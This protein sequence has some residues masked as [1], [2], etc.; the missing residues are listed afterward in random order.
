MTDTYGPLAIPVPVPAAGTAG[1]DPLLDTLLA[2]FKAALD[3]GMAEA[4]QARAPDGDAAV[5]TVVVG[6]PDL[7]GIPPQTLPALYLHRSAMGRPVWDASDWRVRP[8]TLLLSY[9]WPLD[10]DQD[11]GL[12]RAAF[13]NAAEAILDAAIERGRTPGWVHPGDL[14]MSEVDADGTSP[15]TVTL[16]GTPESAVTTLL[17]EIVD[18]GELG[19][20]TFRWSLDNGDTWSDPAEDTAASVALAGS[21]LTAAF[22]AGNYADDNVY[23][24]VS[25]LETRDDRA[26]DE[27]SLVWRFAPGVRELSIGGATMRPLTVRM[28]ATQ[29]AVVTLQRLE[30]TLALRERILVDLAARYD[31]LDDID[32]TATTEPEVDDTE[33]TTG[34]VL[35]KHVLV[36]DDT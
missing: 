1:G 7:L 19:V 27:G 14:E 29:S 10:G 9:V 26:E 4:W 22:G 35:L 33:I 12:Q 36:D 21:G 34:H 17:V 6:N 32:L 5:K 13:G 11:R 18:P 25:Q 24:A 20:A 15:P 28:R 16:S 2:F 8:S 31:E 30:V 3:D 23:T